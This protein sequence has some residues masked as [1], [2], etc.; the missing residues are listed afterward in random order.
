[1]QTPKECIGCPLVFSPLEVVREALHM[2]KLT[3]G[4]TLIDLG[5]GDGRVIFEGV[6]RAGIRGSTSTPFCCNIYTICD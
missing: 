3:E 2:A 6:K 5:C 4:D 1:M